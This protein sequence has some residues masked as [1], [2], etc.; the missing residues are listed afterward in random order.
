[1]PEERLA[2]LVVGLR[3]IH[4]GHFVGAINLSHPELPNAPESAVTTW[5]GANSDKAV[6]DEITRVLGQD[7]ASQVVCVLLD[8]LIRSNLLVDTVT[9]IWR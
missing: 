7:R 5:L 3:S 8:R 2:D 4:L 6:F 9:N 1:M